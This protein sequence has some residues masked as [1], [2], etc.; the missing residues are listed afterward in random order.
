[1]KNVVYLK[2]RREA[3]VQF[4]GVC[5]YVNFIQNCSLFKLDNFLNFTGLHFGQ[6]VRKYLQVAELFSYM[7]SFDMRYH[8]KWVKY[9]YEFWQ[10]MPTM[11][12]PDFW[13]E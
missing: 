10:K 6:D 12:T 1:M 8:L 2:G 4:V 9:I 11:Q 5:V 3:M 13:M 7:T